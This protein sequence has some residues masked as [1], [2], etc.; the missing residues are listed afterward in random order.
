[1][2]LNE[3]YNTSWSHQSLFRLDCS[4]DHRLNVCVFL[5]Y[6]GTIADIFDR[7]IYFLNILDPKGLK[8]SDKVSEM[9]LK[10][11]SAGEHESDSIYFTL[12][13]V[14]LFPRCVSAYREMQGVS[15]NSE[16]LSRSSRVC[17]V[18]GRERERSGPNF[19]L[20]LTVR[21]NTSQ[22]QLS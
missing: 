20:V 2:A 12:L 18:L 4:S 3:K 7:L 21:D 5:V 11:Q 17:V 6:N 14:C 19:S 1:M 22:Q 8:M 15:E 9:W 16:K 13:S 10:L